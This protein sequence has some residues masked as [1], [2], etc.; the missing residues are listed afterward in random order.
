MEVLAEESEAK[1]TRVKL[2]ETKKEQEQEN[3]EVAI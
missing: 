2:R 3:A 1:K